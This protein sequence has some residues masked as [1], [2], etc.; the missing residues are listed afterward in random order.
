[1]KPRSMRLTKLVNLSTRHAVVIHGGVWAVR[2][3]SRFLGIAIAMFYNDHAPPHFHARY[4]ELEIRVNI[5]TGQ[6]LSGSFPRRAQSF[7]L[8]RLELYRAELMQI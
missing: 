1:M 8:E 7:V 2:D 6:V 5:E 3:I 4:G